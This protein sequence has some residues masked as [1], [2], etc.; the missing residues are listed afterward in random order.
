MDLTIISLL[1]FACLLSI[2]RTEKVDLTLEVGVAGA[3]T[4]RSVLNKLEHKNFLDLPSGSVGSSQVNEQ[5]MREMAYVASQDGERPGGSGVK[6]GIWRLDEKVFKET[7]SYNYFSVYQR[8]CEAF[9]ID[10]VTVT[11]EDLGKPLYSGLAV[12]IYMYHLDMVGNGLPVGA[13]D[14]TKATF[15]LTFF[16]MNQHQS[17]SIWFIYIAQL[18]REEGKVFLIIYKI[19]FSYKGKSK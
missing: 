8:I 7:Q 2:S 18:R 13:L 14:R 1:V 6:G 12:A 16:Q 9:C 4:V 11:Y 17:V 15:W 10:W 5:F 19:I 3:E